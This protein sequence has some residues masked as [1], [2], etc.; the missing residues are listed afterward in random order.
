M[1]ITTIQQQPSQNNNIPYR[2]TQLEQVLVGFGV[3]L[4]LIALYN[5]AFDKF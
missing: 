1:Y 5:I 3:G 4:I 2:P